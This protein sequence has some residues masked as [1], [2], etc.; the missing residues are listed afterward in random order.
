MAAK[1]NKIICF[2]YNLQP[3]ILHIK[4]IVIFFDFVRCEEVPSIFKEEEKV[5]TTE[6]HIYLFL[7]WIA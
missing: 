2:H 4:V 7:D 5:K 3:N 1:H 6:I